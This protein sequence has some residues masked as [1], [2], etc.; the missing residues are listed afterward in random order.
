MLTGAGQAAHAG[1]RAGGTPGCLQ[2]E[3][4]PEVSPKVGGG[5]PAAPVLA[6]KVGG[7]P[8]CPT[9]STAELT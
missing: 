6:G 5:R 7:S 1:G 2:A 9:P 4:C 8:V 3:P